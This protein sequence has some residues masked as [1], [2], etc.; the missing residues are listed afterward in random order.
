M[1]T[2]LTLVLLAGASLLHATPAEAGD[3]CREYRKQ[4]KVGGGVQ[5]AYGT[6]CM[7]PDGSWE[8]V[9]ENGRP[10]EMYDFYGQPTYTFV[11]RPVYTPPMI[12]SSVVFSGHDSHRHRH[13][14]HH[15]GCGH[16]H[17]HKGHHYG[18]HKHHKKHY[19][20]HRGHHHDGLSFV[21]NW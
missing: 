6:A 7:Q 18:H 15:H 9:S 1:R 21:F 5:E 11:E 10:V 3:Y 20:H 2:F 8:I 16:G 13:H 4:V 17:G 19:S 14:R 12:F